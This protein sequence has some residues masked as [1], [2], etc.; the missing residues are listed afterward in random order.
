MKSSFD[1]QLMAANVQKHECNETRVTGKYVT[2]IREFLIMYC[3]LYICLVRY[4][5]Y[6]VKTIFLCIK[7]INNKMAVNI[8]AKE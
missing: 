5:K 4:H 1:T 2:I 3:F 7:T 6:P 8:L